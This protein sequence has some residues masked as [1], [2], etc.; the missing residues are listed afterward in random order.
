MFS[1]SMGELDGG[2]LGS[3]DKNTG[4]RDGNGKI[5][6]DVGVRRGRVAEVYGGLE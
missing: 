3:V 4:F 6:G 5:L 2:E 1:I